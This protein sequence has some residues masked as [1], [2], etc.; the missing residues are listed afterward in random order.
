ML[1]NFRSSS[2]IKQN[3]YTLV[4]AQGKFSDQ[5][6]FISRSNGREIGYVYLREFQAKKE[7]WLVNLG[8]IPKSLKSKFEKEKIDRET[9]VVG[10]LKKSETSNLSKE[11][12]DMEKD[13][14]GFYQ[15][16]LSLLSEFTNNPINNLAYIGTFFGYYS[17]LKKRKI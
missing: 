7:S 12:R 2:N 4:Q 17:I 3:E 8:W 10:L 14:D 15:V 13:L 9:E 6:M 1:I 16:D 11:Q 5:A